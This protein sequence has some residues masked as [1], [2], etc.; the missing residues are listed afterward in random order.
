[1]TVNTEVSNIDINTRLYTLSIRLMSNGFSF[2]RYDILSENTYT[3]KEYSFPSGASYIQAF[4]NAVLNDE[5]FLQPYKDIYIIIATDHFTI[6][7]GEFS[8]EENNL[9]DFYSLNIDSRNEK[10]LHNR[11]RQTNATV[12]FGLNIELYSFLMR[13]FSSPKICHTHTVLNEYFIQKSRLGNSAKM[14]CQIRNGK[15]DI[16][17]HKRGKLVLSNMFEYNSIED[18]A[19]Y[20]LSC[21]KNIGYNNYNDMLQF[22]GNKEEIAAIKAI[23]SDYLA[24]IEPVVFPAQIFK[25]GKESLKAPFDLISISLCEL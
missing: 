8:T 22:T 21:W 9:K 13:T 14:I 1:M 15:M 2:S 16:L 24:Q 4:E 11:L 12:V 3:Y 6:V 5:L 20:L 18:A 17:C 7:P 10:I 25:L 19:F 23:V